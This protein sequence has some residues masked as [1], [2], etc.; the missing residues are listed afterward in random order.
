M[1]S[2][3]KFYIFEGIAFFL[4]S[5]TFRNFS[6]EENLPVPFMI[7]LNLKGI[8]NCV[9]ILLF[10]NLSSLSSL[11]QVTIYSENFT[12]Q[13]GQGAV[14]PGG[15]NPTINTSA[16]A[17]TIDVSNCSLSAN[18]DWFR[19]VNGVFEARDIDGNA[20]WQSPPINIAAYSNVS[21][22]LSASENG[23]MESGDL[24]NTEYRIDGG[25]WTSADT[26]GTLNDDFSAATV[27]QGALS[28]GTLEI[29]VVMNNNAASE[30]HRLDNIQVQGIFANSDDIDTEVIAPTSQVPSS[31]PNSITATSASNSFPVLRFAIEDQGTSD[32]LSTEVIRMRFAPGPNNSADWTDHIQGVKIEDDVSTHTP[33]SV[34]ISDSQIVLN[35]SP[36]IAVPDG[37]A[38]RVEFEVGIFLNTSNIEDGAIIQFQI[39]AASSGFGAD[40]SGSGFA[41]PFPSG[42]VV[43]NQHT[44]DVSAA[45]LSFSVSPVNA[46]INTAMDTVKVSAT[47]ANGNTDLDYNSNVSITSTGTLTNSPLSETAVNGVASFPSITH[48]ALGTGLQLTASDGSLNP[49]VSGSFDIIPAPVIP[50]LIISEVSDPL[51]LPDGKFVEIYNYG[52]DTIH[53]NEHEIHLVRQA[54]GGSEDAIDLNTIILPPKEMAVIGSGGDNTSFNAAYG[55]DPDTS[56]GFISGNGNDG[57]FLYFEGDNTTGTLFDAYGETGVDGF[58]L[59]WDYEDSRAIRKNPDNATPSSTWNASEWIVVAANASDCTPGALENEYRYSTINQVGSWK[60]TTPTNVTGDTVRVIGQVSLSNDL[61]CSQLEVFASHQLEM[62]PG[63][64]VVIEDEFINN[65]LLRLRAGPIGYSQMKLNGSYTG[66]GVVAQQQYTSVEGWHPIGAPF[67]AAAIDSLGNQVN[68]FANIFYWNT[69]SY[70]YSAPANQFVPGRGYIAYFGLYGISSDATGP[71]TFELSGTPITSVTPTIEY[72]TAA[73][74]S[75]SSFNGNNPNQNGWNLIS[76][77]FNCNL[78]FETLSLT[79]MEDAFY[80]FNENNNSWRSYSPAGATPSEI[81][82]L[83]G[84]W[85]RARSTGPPSIGTLTPSGNGTV[86]GPVNFFK[87]AFNKIVLTIES[88]G[89]SDVLTFAL[90]PNTQ[91]GFDPEWDAWK[92]ENRS[93]VPNL[94][95]HEGNEDMAINAV[96]VPSGQQSVHDVGIRCDS[97]GNFTIRMDSSYWDVQSPYQVWLYDNKTDTEHN[98]LNGDYTFTHDTTYAELRFELRIRDPL[99]QTEEQSRVEYVVL[100]GENQWIIHGLSSEVYGFEVRNTEGGI[101]SRGNLNSSNNAIANQNLSSGVYFIEL[102]TKKGITLLKA[103]K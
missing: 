100:Q 23:N 88:N 8:R 34:I 50:S 73:N 53:F 38:N 90:I 2:S 67:T 16:V 71:W 87:Q 79:N 66:T 43:G 17:W 55:Y 77:P 26:N 29:R 10:F 21:F 54:N 65:G 3:D 14:G 56:S 12:G 13:N 78:D 93:G 11:G 63:F 37:P 101:V 64:D 44:I 15:S 92:L 80:K 99:F 81:A 46:I 36:G 62:A 70:D 33:S 30:Y 5:K 4:L 59:A 51:D 82:P 52:S 48:S 69:S 95:S 57:Y 7:Y 24:F 22:S 85:V 84:F 31:N 42:D 86:N 74:G 60:P 20:I 1:L 91:D 9:I 28:G 40:I 75:W 47:D 39:D 76:N 61:V 41:N 49:V 102:K 18:S 6:H 68:D 19:V 98:L 96:P 103:P 35:F 72:Q 97:L 89:K 83:Q 94:Y 32:G 25:A 58:G 27:S 45:Q